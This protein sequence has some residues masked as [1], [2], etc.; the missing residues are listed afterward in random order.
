MEPA[1]TAPEQGRVLFLQ[2]RTKT[3]VL[4]QKVKDNLPYGSAV[5]IGSRK[6]AVPDHIS[7]REAAKKFSEEVVACTARWL[8]DI[9][10]DFQPG[11]AGAPK[12]RD[13]KLREEREARRAPRSLETLDTTTLWARLEE[14]YLASS[15]LFSDPYQYKD[16]RQEELSFT[17]GSR[18]NLDEGITWLLHAFPSLYQR[19]LSS[20]DLRFNTPTVFVYT[21]Y[22][23]KPP[24]FHVRLWGPEIVWACDLR[25]E[26]L[27]SNLIASNEPVGSRHV[28]PAA[29][30]SRRSRFVK[31]SI[32]ITIR[33]D[34]P[35]DDQIREA[36]ERLKKKHPKL[37]K[38]FFLALPIRPA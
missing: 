9:E 4:E 36:R 16:R 7:I 32:I 15:E 19:A 26:V 35:C 28:N 27:L 21:A 24:K 14:M 8:P 17:S 1:K 22:D 38:E 5:R 6:V 23:N 31:D 11:K 37:S 18:E 29:G 34:T 3:L 13:L 12:I 33:P 20:D 25:F 2:G 10:V 30:L